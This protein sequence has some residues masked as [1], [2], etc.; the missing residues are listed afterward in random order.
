MAKNM[1]N[2]T[3]MELLARLEDA[4]RYFQSTEFREIYEKV[5]NTLHF[6]ERFAT[7][8]D[9][10]RT[11]RELERCAYTVKDYLTVEETSRYLQ[12]HKSMIYRLTSNKEITY[13]KPNGKTIFIRRADLEEWISQTPILSND[14]MKRRANYIYSQL[15]KDRKKGGEK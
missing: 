4:Q 1:I 6:F 14:E 5:Y 12:V 9:V 3:D 8:E 13:Y 11:M 10:V 15:E 2:K 7:L